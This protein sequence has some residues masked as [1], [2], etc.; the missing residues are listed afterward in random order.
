MGAVDTRSLKY[1]SMAISKK[2]T[3]DERSIV[4]I[5]KFVI[6]G[7]K[8]LQTYYLVFESKAGRWGLLD[9]GKELKITRESFNPRKIGVESNGVQEVFREV[10]ATN[11]ISTV[12]LNPD[13][14]KVRRMMR[15]VG[16]LEYGRVLF[17]FD[18]S[19]DNCL[20]ELISFTGKDGEPDNLVD[21]F[22]YAMQMAK[23]GGSSDY[24]DEETDETTSAEGAKQKF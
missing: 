5:V 22:N 23:E 18:G 17:P 14:D 3:S 6:R 12:A 9:Y 8:P 15:N 13:G 11:D 4:T 1:W 10:F 16:D 2:E 21:G 24:K 19:C 20:N 7:T